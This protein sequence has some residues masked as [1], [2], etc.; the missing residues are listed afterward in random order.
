ML[1]KCKQCGQKLV[2]GPAQ[3]R[4]AEAA[5]FRIAINRIPT[6]VC[7]KGCP[8]L[9]WNHPDL[10]EEINDLV[11]FSKEHYAGKK[12]LFKSSLVCPKC[13]QELQ[14]AAARNIFSFSKASSF[15]N[16]GHP[17]EVLVETSGLYCRSCNLNYLPPHTSANE[18]FYTEL[19]QLI[20]R[21]LSK[22][23]IWK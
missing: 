15:P 13:G 19:G 20:G 18:S 4:S 22:D 21:A 12:G 14:A 10:A 17:L 23:L 7:P 1:S 5:K 16:P 3:T 9:Y 8:G 2:P 11:M 6:K